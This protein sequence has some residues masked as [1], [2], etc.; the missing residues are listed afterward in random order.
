VKSGTHYLHKLQCIFI[1]KSQLS[2]YAQWTVCVM[3]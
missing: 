3:A 1:T 2:N